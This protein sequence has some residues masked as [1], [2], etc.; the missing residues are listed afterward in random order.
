MIQSLGV[1]C[2][3]RAG[4]DPRLVEST[5]V[6]GEMMGRRGLTLVYGGGSLGL[7][8]TLAD[9]CLHAGG[10]V[11][12]VIPASMVDKEQAHPDAHEMHVVES[13][14]QRKILMME[15]SEAYCVLPGGIGTLDELFEVLTSIQL[16]F[17]DARVGLLNCDGYWGPQIRMLDAMVRGGFL[18]ES[19]RER[20]LVET[21]P[22]RMLDA[23]L[24]D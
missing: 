17:L 22:E 1:F 16:G 18:Y 21:E 4:N 10:R 20:L 5:R 6:F 8:G 11:V 23:L 14:A 2:A 19:T 24:D 7:M 15:L 13:M 9:A 12:G 3:A